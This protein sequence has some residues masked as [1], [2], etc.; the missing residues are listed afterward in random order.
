MFY[1][2]DRIEDG[3]AVLYDDDENKTD[4]PVC[5]LPENINE[6]DILR[7]DGENDAYIIDKE[8]TEQIKA[9]LEER[10]KNLL[11]K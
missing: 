10:F 7:F 5:K 8:K 4:I 9:D 11:K 2:V 1:T 6:G 3:I